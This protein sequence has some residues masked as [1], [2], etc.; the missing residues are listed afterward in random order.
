MKD[1]IACAL[2]R[3]LYFMAMVM[4]YSKIHGMPEK[5]YNALEQE[6]LE[7]LNQIAFTFKE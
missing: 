1:R 5:S 6:R 7:T 3:V 4:F 2:V